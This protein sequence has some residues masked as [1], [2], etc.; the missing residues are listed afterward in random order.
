[1]KGTVGASREGLPALALPRNISLKCYWEPKEGK[2]PEPSAHVTARRFGH[3]FR[4]GKNFFSLTA[5]ANY[6]NISKMNPKRKNDYAE[7][8]GT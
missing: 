5:F 6:D 3:L 1:M 8:V 4:A 2:F 7:G